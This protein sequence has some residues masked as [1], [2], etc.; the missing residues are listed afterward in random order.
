MWGFRNTVPAE[1]KKKHEEPASPGVV[2]GTQDLGFQALF[3]WL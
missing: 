2:E 1:V 3:S